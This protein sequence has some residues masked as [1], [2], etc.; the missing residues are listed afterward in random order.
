M[1]F[2]DKI[3]IEIKNLSSTE[4]IA[5]YIFYSAK[6]AMLGAKLRKENRPDES[7]TEQEHKEWDFICDELEP[8][9]HALSEE[10]NLIINENIG[11]FMAKLIR[12]ESIL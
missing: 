5:G 10:E 6:L 3:F 8:W 4:R 2:N 7:W 1:N 9:H 12:G 11:I